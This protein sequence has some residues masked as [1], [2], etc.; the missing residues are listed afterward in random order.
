G[1]VAAGG[2][3]G[4]A[5]AGAAGMGGAG[6]VGGLL[7]TKAGVVALVVAGSSMAAGIGMLATMSADRRASGPE[8]GLAFLP[9]RA[10]RPVSDS[11]GSA[12]AGAVSR[13][14]VSTSLDYFNK[15]NKGDVPQPDEGRDAVEESDSPAATDSGVEAPDH[16]SAPASSSSRKRAAAKKPKMVKSKGFAG[17]SSGSSLRMASQSGLSGGIG[18]G[19]QET[20]QRPGP[21]SAMNNT[22]SK[23]ASRR[24]RSSPLRNKSLASA[25]LRAHSGRL[26]RNLASGNV[27]SQASGA[28]M[29]G[30]GGIGQIGAAPAGIEGGGTGVDGGGVQSDAVNP[31]TMQNTR[32]TEAPPPPDPNKD[33]ENKT[34]YQNLMYA[35]MGMIALAGIALMAASMLSKKAKTNPALLPWAKILAGVAMAAAVAAAAIGVMLMTKYGQK[36]QGIMFSA[37]GAIIA[38][39]AGMV[40]LDDSASDEA[41]KG[42]DA[43]LLK[44][45]DEMKAKMDP[46]YEN[47][48][49]FFGKEPDATK[50]NFPDDAAGQMNADSSYYNTPDGRYYEIPKDQSVHQVNIEEG[51]MARVNE[52]ISVNQAPSDIPEA[53]DIKW[54]QETKK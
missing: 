40:L 51:S 35:A 41:K 16:R 34:P 3:A 46:S 47:A 45:G 4:G 37:I 32:V 50:M 54:S 39:Q 2:G 15:A 38:F 33:A 12:G 29:D 5:A 52:P 11:A 18:G 27:S 19:F 9:K 13:D 36:M 31:N 21:T 20:Y 14:G 43:E 42:T 30:G 25:Q 24:S 53:K 22:R 1:G 10:A 8:S 28:V 6:L 7:A 23:M 26:K 44:G 49:E 48:D 17:Q